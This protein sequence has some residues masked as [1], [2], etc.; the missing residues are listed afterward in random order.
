MYASHSS[1]RDD[2]EVSC[3]ELD[4]VVEIAQDIGRKGGVSGCRMTGGGFGGCAVA[5]VRTD[6]VAAI[7]ER[8]ASEYE[9]RTR[10]KPTLFVSRPAAGATV[11]KG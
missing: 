9:R 4:A 7:S 3:P 2:Y 8:I 6:A 11:L 5:L 10:I 1:L